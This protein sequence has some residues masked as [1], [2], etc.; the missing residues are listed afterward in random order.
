MEGE[1]YASLVTQVQW[2]VYVTRRTVII[3][4]INPAISL[5]TG[6]EGS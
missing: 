2:K 1:E 6:Y 3:R 4:T 5:L